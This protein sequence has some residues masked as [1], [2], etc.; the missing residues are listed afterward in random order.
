MTMVDDTCVGSKGE[1]GGYCNVT[2]CSNPNPEYFNKSTKA[3]YCKECAKEINWPGG[4]RL[5]M[6]LYGTPFLCELD[7]PDTKETKQNA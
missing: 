2:A 4:R 6:Q 7:Q 1:K 5:T 3:Y